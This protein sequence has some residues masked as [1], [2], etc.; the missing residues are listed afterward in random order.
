MSSRVWLRR[1]YDEPTHNDGYRILVDR[2]WPRG[3]SKV[4]LELDEWCRDIAPSDELRKWFDHD[5]ARW[6]EFGERYRSELDDH[7]DLLDGFV[8]RVERGRITLVYAAR[9]EEHN[10]AIVLRAV[11][12]ERS[13]EVRGSV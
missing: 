8:D 10:N 12:D 6:D 5:P 4:D 11:I 2:L 7:R 1:A 3:V 13:D 9:D